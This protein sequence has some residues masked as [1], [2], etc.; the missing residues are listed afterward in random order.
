MRSHRREVAT[1]RPSVAGAFS[2]SKRSILMTCQRQ[3]ISIGRHCV[4]FRASPASVPSVWLWPNS[5]R[6]IVHFWSLHVSYRKLSDLGIEDP[7][8]HWKA[9]Y[10][11]RT[12]AH[13]WEAADGFPS[14]IAQALSQSRSHS[15]ISCRFSQCRSS[16]FHFRDAAVGNRSLASSARVLRQTPC[17]SGCRVHTCCHLLNCRR[18]AVPSER[19]SRSHK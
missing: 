3:R 6:R 17:I 13:C 18:S 8:K 9:G 12:L 10:S 11:A 15:R 4:R 16:R 19:S 2:S 5:E 1:W 14:E 7:V